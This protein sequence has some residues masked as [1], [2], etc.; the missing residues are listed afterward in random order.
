MALLLSV[1]SGK[2]LAFPFYIFQSRVLLHCKTH[3][4]AW[5][6]SKEELNATH[7]HKHTHSQTHKQKKFRGII[8]SCDSGSGVKKRVGS[9]NMETNSPIKEMKKIAAQLR[10]LPSDTNSLESCQ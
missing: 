6:R 2:F 1:A 10:L 3:R 8:G 5:N 7:S 4:C 9:S